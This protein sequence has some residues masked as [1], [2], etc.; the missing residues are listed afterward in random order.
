M[1]RL[2][3][4]INNFVGRVPAG[5]ELAVMEK[6]LGVESAISLMGFNEIGMFDHLF[7]Q[8]QYAFIKVNY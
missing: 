2:I 5:Y 7:E 1:I 4:N 8:P 3:E 6:R